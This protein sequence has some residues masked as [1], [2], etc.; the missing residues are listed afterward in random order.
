V[1]NA[2]NWGARPLKNGDFNREDF[3]ICRYGASGGGSFSCEGP[4][5]MDAIQ[6]NI[7]SN[8]DRFQIIISPEPVDPG[9]QGRTNGNSDGF[10][11]YVN[12]IEL[13]L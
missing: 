13:F 11:Y 10:L 5:L 4:Q 6:D 8:T 9:N 12:N 2:K 3:E 7:N 1:F